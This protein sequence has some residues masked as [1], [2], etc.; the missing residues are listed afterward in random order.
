[1]LPKN[2]AIALSR[3]ARCATF[4]LAFSL[5]MA[6]CGAA[7]RGNSAGAL[8]A[9]SPIPIP[10]LFPLNEGFIHNYTTR[11]DEGQPASLLA[12]AARTGPSSGELRWGSSSRRFEFK[13]DG[14]VNSATGAYVL[15]DPIAV[16]ASWRGDHGITR[17]TSVDASPVVPAGRFTS[18]V[19]TVE[20]R[21]GD[22]PLRL[23][24]VYCPDVGI[25]IFEASSG[26]DAARVELKSYAPPV[27]VGPDGLTITKP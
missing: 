19:E 15:K 7:P 8:G 4:G 13:Q 22:S 17:V 20:E 6:A 18:C 3:A 16:G 2:A 24:T 10:R 5:F 21:G 25:V 1:M 23:L 27:D 12:R 14:V 26:M 9:R 11:S